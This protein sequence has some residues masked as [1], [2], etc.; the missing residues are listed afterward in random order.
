MR[1]YKNEMCPPNLHFERGNQVHAPEPYNKHTFVYISPTGT[2]CLGKD[3][4]TLTL[5]QWT[6]MCSHLTDD[7]DQPSFPTS[8]C[9]SCAKEDKAF[10]EA[11]TGLPATPTNIK[12]ALDAKVVKT[13]KQLEDVPTTQG[14][15]PKKNGNHNKK[16]NNK[17]ATVTPATANKRKC[18]VPSIN[19]I[20]KDVIER[21]GE[22]K[23]EDISSDVALTQLA[24]LMRLK[25]M[26]AVHFLSDNKKMKMVFTLCQSCNSHR[27]CKMVSNLSPFC[28]DCQLANGKEKQL[29]RKREENL[30][31][32]T[33]A[34]STT[35]LTHLTKE[36][37]K[38]RGKAMKRQHDI[39]AIR[40]KRALATKD[41]LLNK[42]SPGMKT[43][44]EN[45]FHFANE[46][47]GLVHD[48]VSKVLR[49]IIQKENT[50]LGG[51]VLLEEDCEPIV[52]MIIDEIRNQCRVF[53]NQ[54]T[55]C[56]YSSSL[57]GLAMSLF[58]QSGPAAYEQFR[59]DSVMIY[60]SSSYLKSLKYRQDTK[61]G[62]SVSQYEDQ[63]KLRD[64]P[65]EIG[66]LIVD[67]MKLKKDVV[68]NVK[69]GAVVGLTDDFISQTKIIKT[70]LD[71]DKPNDMVE[72]ATH[73]NQWQYR[74]ITG[75]TFNCEFFYNAGSL[76]GNALLEQFTRVVVN[77]E[78]VGSKVFGLVCDAGGN[79]ARLMNLL[80]RSGT[81]FPNMAWVEEEDD[82]R[83]V[84]PFDPSRFIYLFFCST[85]DL[86]NVRGALFKSEPGGKRELLDAEGNHIDK[87][88]LVECLSRDLDRLRRGAKPMTT[89]Q[90]STIKLDR[91]SKMN[92][93]EAKRIC[94]QKTL[95]EIANY[96]YCRLGF[97]ADDG[98]LLERNHGRVGYW[99]AVALHLKAKLGEKKSIGNKSCDEANVLA[100]A[101]SS[102]EWIANMHEIF[103]NRLMNME[104]KI[105]GGNIDSFEAE[106]IKNLNYF[107]DLWT[108]QQKRKELLQK[109]DKSWQKDFLASETWRNLRMTCRGFFGY[110]RYVIQYAASHR[111]TIKF[112]GVSPAHSNS[113]VIE[114]W[115]SLVRMA[116]QDDGARYLAYATNRQMVNAQNALKKNRNKM[117]CEDDV[118]DVSTGKDVGIPELIKFKKDR[119]MR[120][121]SLIKG[122]EKNRVRESTIQTD[123]FSMTAEEASLPGSSNQEQEV[124]RILTTL[125]LP[126]GYMA[127]LT[128]LA[129]FH[130]WVRLCL[131]NNDVGQWFDELFRLTSTQEGSIQFNAGCRAI[132]DKLL[133]LAARCMRNRTDNNTSFEA[134]AHNFYKSE[135][136]DV[137]CGDNLPGNLGKSHPGCV[138]LGLM[139]AELLVKWLAL[140]LRMF[141]QT[142]NPELFRKKQNAL[143]SAEENNEVNSFLGWSIFSA[144]KKFVN[145]DEKGSETECKELLRTM[146]ISEADADE[147]YLATYYDTN[148]SMLNHGG[149]TLVSKEFFEWGKL[150]MQSIRDAFTMDHIKSAPRSCFNDRKKYVLQN[151]SIRSSFFISC[152]SSPLSFSAKTI[153]TVYDIIVPK[154]IHARFAV[155]FRQWKQLHCRKH[156]VS[157]RTKLKATVKDDKKRAATNQH[158]DESVVNNKMAKIT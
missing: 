87:S 25:D 43:N 63:L 108:A 84:N 67:E 138:L 119:E 53:N 134:A 50:T 31:E 40:L 7:L 94:A 4:W 150:T 12:Q 157:L 74:S 20:E 156:E 91:W 68:I 23:A 110:C 104:M 70:W 66:Q 15:R 82:V 10:F 114:A 122:Y 86:K 103:T 90:E 64:S 46:N 54:K 131:D 124:L 58:L 3:Q 73:V 44:V 100:S 69:S 48:Q 60:P 56:K 147:A 9:T 42:M 80:R 17:P 92:V 142:I 117:Y 78:L 130:Q 148:M 145:A 126:N 79:N 116:R 22:V 77:C 132:Q 106:I 32:R 47:T 21:L 38:L 71:K 34:S 158:A 27:A 129:T 81:G 39:I 133:Q 14:G 35:P 98:R 101:I 75:R 18:I 121:D 120:K 97:P 65:E 118:G 88:I 83:T 111:D 85:H 30:S 151:K 16:N 5:I 107:H 28:R 139:L 45:S 127:R 109:G 61:D 59:R 152:Q 19:A 153:S 149:L 89:L 55:Q 137:M 41:E 36:E 136:F 135:E 33:A 143:T 105:N 24:G 140:A 72:P 141:R 29:Q 155:V 96:L 128:E 112:T 26:T 146:S 115:F 49:E 52:E 1:I 2:V 37:L 8:S 62:K 6:N 154:M 144:T 51:K 11:Y 93:E 113:S 76:S 95:A 123:K 13:C 125:K 102:F 57:V 99:P